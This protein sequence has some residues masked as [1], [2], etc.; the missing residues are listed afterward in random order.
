MML[1]LLKMHGAVTLS[2]G[3]LQYILFDGNSGHANVCVI[4]LDGTLGR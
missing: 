3:A 1:K 2:F 4:E